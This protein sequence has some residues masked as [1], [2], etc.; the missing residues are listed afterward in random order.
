MVLKHIEDAIR[1]G[2]TIRAVIRG[3]GINS[4][5]K[6]PGITLPSAQAQAALIRSTYKAAGLDLTETRYFE[7]HVTTLFICPYFLPSI[8]QFLVVEITF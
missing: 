5:G 6:T 1:D 7:A 4:D 8:K 3:S 2:D